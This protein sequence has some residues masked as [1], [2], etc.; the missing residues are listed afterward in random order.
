MT[1]HAHFLSRSL[2]L[3]LSLLSLSRSANL[4]RAH[5]LFLPLPHP[6]LHTAHFPRSRSRFLA[7]ML[8]YKIR[9]HAGCARGFYLDS[10]RCCLRRQ[11]KALNKNKK[12]QVS[13][14]QHRSGNSTIPD[15]CVPGVRCSQC[16]CLPPQPWRASSLNSPPRY[17]NNKKQKARTLYLFILDWIVALES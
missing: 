6:N 3:P 2:S 11:K 8:R 13:S 16:A 9:M 10:L 12:K 15:G 7:C 5:A 1:L 4:F 17:V 14:K